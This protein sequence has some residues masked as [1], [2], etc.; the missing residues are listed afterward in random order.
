MVTLDS[1]IAP[2]RRRTRRAPTPV[3]TPVKRRFYSVHEAAEQLNLSRRTVEYSIG[4]GDLPVVY[5]PSGDPDSERRRRVIPAAWLDDAR[6]LGMQRGGPVVLTSQAVLR[7]PAD[8]YAMT[9]LQAAVALSVSDT[10]VYDLIRAR[11]FAPVVEAPNGRMMVTTDALDAWCH[12][13][14]VDAE[15][16][17]GVAS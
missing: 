7:A 2:P 5:L 13:L 11:R 3:A 1:T 17:W 16:A 9:I 4:R 10:H 6:W 8:P 12:A 14:I 15:R